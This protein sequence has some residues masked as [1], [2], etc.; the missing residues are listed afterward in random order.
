M[1]SLPKHSRFEASSLSASTLRERYRALKTMVRRAGTLTL[2]TQYAQLFSYMTLLS[3]KTYPTRLPR[4][5]APPPDSDIDQLW[6]EVNERI[7]KMAHR[8]E[9]VPL[10]ASP[11]TSESS[12]ISHRRRDYDIAELSPDLPDDVTIPRYLDVDSI[13]GD[14]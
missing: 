4:Y 2:F 12:G 13:T 14:P 9:K 3:D 10:L 11:V 7:A 1:A 8:S 5:D 6:E